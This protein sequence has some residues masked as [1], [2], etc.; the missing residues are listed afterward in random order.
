MMSPVLCPHGIA[1]SW[2]GTAMPGEILPPCEHCEECN[3]GAVPLSEA[4]A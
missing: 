4:D 1:T 2:T 3:P